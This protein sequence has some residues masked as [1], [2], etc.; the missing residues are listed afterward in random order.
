ML[1]WTMQEDGEAVDL[2]AS[3]PEEVAPTKH[4]EPEPDAARIYFVRM[5]R[6][7][8]DDALLKRLQTEFQ[9]HITEI[10]GINARLA[11]K[12]VSSTRMSSAF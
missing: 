5:P 9:G 7:P 1:S 4:A 11:A 10:K 8:M 3:Q 2:V 12:R 6:P